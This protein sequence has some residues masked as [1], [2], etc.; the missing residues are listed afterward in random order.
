M[1]TDTG[2]S[3]ATQVPF[4]C[5]TPRPATGTLIAWRADGSRTNAADIGA[6]SL[7]ARFGLAQERVAIGMPMVGGGGGGG[8]EPATVTYIMR[9]T[10]ADGAQFVYWETDDPGASP[11]STYPTAVGTLTDV[12]IFHELQE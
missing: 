10:D 1:A 3:Y 2:F 9:A 11:T 12:R 5:A 6:Y 7:N 4:G 8:A